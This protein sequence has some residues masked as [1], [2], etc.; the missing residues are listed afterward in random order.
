MTFLSDPSGFT[1]RMRP[2]LASRK[3][4]RPTVVLPPD[5]AR[6]ALGTVDADI[7][8]SFFIFYIRAAKTILVLGFMHLL[9]DRSSAAPDL[10]RFLFQI[11]ANSSR[12]ALPFL[13]GLGQNSNCRHWATSY[14]S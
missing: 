1:E 8:V 6:F 3:Y 4:R 12:P 13:F 2:P 11:Y 9:F 14:S 10:L 7:F 5:A